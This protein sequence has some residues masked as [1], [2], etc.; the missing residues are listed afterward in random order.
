MLA[1]LLACLGEIENLR[2]IAKPSLFQGAKVA[3]PGAFLIF[4]LL[5]PLRL[6]FRSRS[7]L[8]VPLFGLIATLFG[9]AFFGSPLLGR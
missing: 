9:L 2:E 6:R 8:V 5:R 3:Q 1:W 7:V 4:H